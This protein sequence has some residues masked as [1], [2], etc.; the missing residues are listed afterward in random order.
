MNSELQDDLKKQIKRLLILV[1][2]REIFSNLDKLKT[3]LLLLEKRLEYCGHCNGQTYE[4]GDCFEHF[5]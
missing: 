4:N 1:D 3:T 5:R 2:S